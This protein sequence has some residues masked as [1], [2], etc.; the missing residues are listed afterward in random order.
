M[1]IDW[2][3]SVLFI[4]ALTTLIMG[5][6]FGGVEWKW[7]SGQSIALFVVS[8]VLFVIFGVQQTFF[9]FC[10][11]QTRLFP[12][13]FLKRRSLLLLF[14]LNSELA[15]RPNVF[16]CAPL[17]HILYPASASS[18][19]FI[20]VYYIPLFFQFT[21]VRIAT[22]IFMQ[23]IWKLILLQGD[24]AIHTS[25]RLL[26]FVLVLIFTIIANG[27][28]MSK[29]GYYIPWYFFGAAFELIAAVLMC[30]FPGNQSFSPL[31]IR[32]AHRLYTN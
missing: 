21:Q 30:M 9:I 31:Q 8:G 4:G 2:V 7:G 19:L 10:N 11:E 3:G 32:G 25:L 16:W 1:N 26:P 18:G 14:I 13:H 6:D 15:P 23:K 27:H 5:I 22:F 29:F 28:M 20:A 17:I 24:T 12:I